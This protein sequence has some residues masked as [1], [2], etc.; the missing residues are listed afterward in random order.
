[1]E[2]PVF[3]ENISNSFSVSSGITQVYHTRRSKFQTIHVVETIPW[4][5]CLLLDGHLQSSE[6]D[7]FVYHENLVHPILLSH[8]NPKTVFIGG[9]G[10]GS[11]L[12]EILKHKSVERVV[13]V[14][15]DEECVDVSKKFL[16]HH[17]NGAY[18]DP[19]VH[20]IIDDAKAWLENSEE[21]FDIIIQDLCDPVDDTPSQL[22]YTQKYYQTCK[23]RL[24]PGGAL[25][26][27]D[28]PAG[29]TSHNMVFTAIHHTLS[30]VFPKVQS[31]KTAI[32]SYVDEWGFSI[33]STDDKY[34]VANMSSSQIDQLI[35]ERIGNPDTLKWY[36][37]EIHSGMFKLPKV[38]RKA[39]QE[40]NRVITEDN[41]LFIP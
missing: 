20:V 39:L 28:G 7:E 32:P 10:E 24:N 4:G 16:T 33:A 22:L 21:K 29:V 35:S 13:M 17:H 2:G 25:I 9:G 11:T 26:T 41:L 27:Q 19:R 34:D 15:I 14:D 18:E 12:R 1:M 36:D 23:A 38:I 3:I 37:G 40:E 8:P 30:T 5:R 31:W 6:R